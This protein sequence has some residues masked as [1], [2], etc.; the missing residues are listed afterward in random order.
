MEGSTAGDSSRALAAARVDNVLLGA[1]VA[2]DPLSVVDRL[3]CVQAQEHAFSRWSVAQR[4]QRPD[5]AA[6]L[7]AMADGD[8]VRTHILRPTWHYVRGDDLRWLQA[9]T[10]PRVRSLSAG[11]YRNH[12]ADDAFFLATRKVVEA[13]LADGRCS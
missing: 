1:G 11:W 2:P 9:L 5:E 7:A 6:V 3:L 12:G 13:E 8:I 10:G 4:T